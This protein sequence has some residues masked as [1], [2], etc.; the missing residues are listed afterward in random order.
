[1]YTTANNTTITNLTLWAPVR[2]NRSVRRVG[3]EDDLLFPVSES[4]DVGEE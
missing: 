3:S 4:K 1:M 2:K